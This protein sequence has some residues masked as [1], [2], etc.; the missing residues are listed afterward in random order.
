MTDPAKFYGMA[1]QAF[2][3]AE[4]CLWDAK[5]FGPND[6]AYIELIGAAIDNLRDARKIIRKLEEPVEVKVAAAEEAEP[7]EKSEKDAM[8]E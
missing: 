8:W 5:D 1:T 2:N 6:K 3:I 4:D 7:Y